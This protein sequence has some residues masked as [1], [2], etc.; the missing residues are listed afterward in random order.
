MRAFVAVVLPEA[1]RAACSGL[2]AELRADFPKV[3]WVRPENIHLTLRFLGEITPEVGERMRQSV[4]AAVADMAPFEVAAR[5]MGCFPNPRR[6]AVVWVGVHP[7]GDGLTRLQQAAER[8]AI[9]AGL[10]PEKRRFVP[11]LTIGRVRRAEMAGGW[12]GAI[13]RYA[14]F[15]AGAWAVRD[16]AL[17]A[18]ELHPAG[19]RYTRLATIPLGIPE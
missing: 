6:P 14:A 19:A 13:A 12:E 5:G 3:R 17:F 4:T 8:C 1:V 2:I 16:V 11:H 7:G 9:D 10:P 18:S 15:D